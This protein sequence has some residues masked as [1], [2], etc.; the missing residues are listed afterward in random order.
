MRGTVEPALD[1]RRAGDRFVTDVGGVRSAHSF[2]FGRHYDPANTSYGVLL[3]HNDELLRA[4]AGFEMHPHRDMEILTWVLE[5]SL[6]HEDSTGHTGVLHPGVAQRMTAGRGVVHAEKNAADASDGAAV[7][8]VQ[9]W[10]VPE[11]QG[12]DPGYEQ[13]EVD[14]PAHGGLATVASG[15]EKHRGS[16]ALRIANRSAALHAAR[17]DASRRVELPEASYLHVFVA[18]GGVTLEG[19]GELAEGDAVRVTGGGGRRV[20]AATPAEVL[21]WEMHASL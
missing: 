12:L 19:A 15:M 7:R 14:F 20:A 6:A 8:F 9:M 18:R 17:L 5:G 16:A 21:V 2:S 1:V 10:V 13:R 3:A 11:E 4:G